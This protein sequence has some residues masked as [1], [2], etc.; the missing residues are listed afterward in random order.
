[1]D[2]SRTVARV[3]ATMYNELCKNIDNREHALVLCL[4]WMEVWTEWSLMSAPE[5]AHVKED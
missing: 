2:A 1:M 5:H 4:K 3:V